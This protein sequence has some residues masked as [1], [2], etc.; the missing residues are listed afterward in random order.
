MDEICSKS[1]LPVAK[2]FQS[3]GKTSRGG[4]LF[5]HFSN[6]KT[7]TPHQSGAERD[8]P[9]SPSAAMPFWEESPDDSIL[10]WAFEATC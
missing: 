6:A 3:W 10:S 2:I 8:H 7:L 1:G 4:R 9:W 5:L